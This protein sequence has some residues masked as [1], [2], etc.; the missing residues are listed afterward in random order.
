MEILRP[1]ER[2]Q[3]PESKKWSTTGAGDRDASVST[4]GMGAPPSRFEVRSYWESLAH[5]DAWKESDAFREAHRQ[6]LDEK[7]RANV[8]RLPPGLVMGRPEIRFHELIE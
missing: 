6:V 7:G 2:M 5:F 1:V 8:D 4:S 3:D